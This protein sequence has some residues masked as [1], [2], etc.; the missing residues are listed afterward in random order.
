MGVQH[1]VI[2][3]AVF[4]WWRLARAVFIRKFG[5]V[6]RRVVLVIRRS[7]GDIRRCV[8]LGWI[9]ALSG[10]VKWGARVLLED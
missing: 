10:A 7:A 5:W 4:L 1:R 6:I 2:A 3:G 9:A 8:D